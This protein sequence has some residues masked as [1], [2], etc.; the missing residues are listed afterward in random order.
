MT[1][2]H[3]VLFVLQTLGAGGSERVVFDVARMI[4]EKGITPI[5]FG[6]SDGTL[7]SHFEQEGIMVVV[8]D[9]RPGLDTHLIR[10][11]ADLVRAERPDIVNTHHFSPLFYAFLGC[12]FSNRVALIHTEHSKWEINRLSRFWKA[13]FSILL[14][15]ADA[16]VGVSRE[17]CEGFQKVLKV[18]VEKI[19]LIANGI[20]IVRFAGTSGSATKRR[21]LGIE[22][23]EKVIGCI[24][25]IRPEKNHKILISAFSLILKKHPEARL[26]LAGADQMGGAIQQFA[27]S[28][29]IGSRVLF[30]GHREDIPELHAVLDVF[31]LP[32]L[33]EGMPISILEA[34]AA[35]VP[36]V[37]TDVLGIR[38]IIT[39]GETG[40]L[41]KSNDAQALADGIERLLADSDLRRYTTRKA[42][43]YVSNHHNM[44]AW[45]DRYKELFSSIRAK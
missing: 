5:V 16:A 25:N 2:A 8:G 31:C 39:S 22:A 44:N 18:P 19:H 13:L 20:D 1:G 30:L 32:S 26:L 36:I 29:G 15:W 27:E 37:A 4:R 11:L 45:I 34:M 43:E 10:R 23:E 7:R 17:T 3:K 6:I 42:F 28:L 12:K 40:L 38:G 9:K 14:K 24:A 33:Y 35:R 21:E 41:V